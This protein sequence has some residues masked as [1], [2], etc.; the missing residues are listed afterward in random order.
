MLQLKVNG[1][2]DTFKHHCETCMTRVS[3]SISHSASVDTGISRR[4]KSLPVEHGT[5]V[6]GKERSAC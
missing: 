3:V 5:A 6:V 2:L 4:E 1:T